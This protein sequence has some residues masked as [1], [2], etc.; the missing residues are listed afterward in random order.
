MKLL[1]TSF[2]LILTLSC[3]KETA[4]SQ[5]LIENKNNSNI[6]NG[7]L[8]ESSN[9]LASHVAL[10]STVDLMGN[11]E[12]CTGVFISMKQILTAAHCIAKNTD[13]MSVTFRTLN[14]DA[15]ANVIDLPIIK[16]KLIQKNQ[17]T[18]RQDL[19]LIEINPTSDLQA[20]PV[21]ILKSEAII[22]K[23][24]LI[25]FG[26]TS[27]TAFINGELRTKNV[28]IDSSQLLKIN[29]EIN[30]AQNNGGVCFGDSGGPALYFDQKLNQYFLVGIASA[31]VRRENSDACLNKSIFM[32]AIFYK[33]EIE[34]LL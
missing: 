18:S 29:F 25:G 13:D 22:S 31:V 4:T 32:N 7:Q 17:S 1:C 15:D 16:V 33:K 27:S 24:S 6:V 11:T 8:V 14:F 23:L 34:D 9:T 20:V 3:K 28:T 30:Q 21:Q 12:I 19:A 2:L 26:A 10:I 5:F